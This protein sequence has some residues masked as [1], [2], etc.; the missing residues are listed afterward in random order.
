MA[1]QINDTSKAR[2]FYEEVR[3]WQSEVNTQAIDLMFFQRILDIYGLKAAES[4][5]AADV[6]HLKRTLTSFL[7]HRVEGH[8]RLLREH[9]D[10]LLKIV[11]D[12][13]LLKDREFPFKHQDVSKEVQDFRVGAQS[14]KTSLYEKI[15]RLKNF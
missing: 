2:E 9:E 10:Y 8:K 15:E 5:D 4:G 11:E 14:L 7:E 6:M 1:I 13:V 3:Q 12:R